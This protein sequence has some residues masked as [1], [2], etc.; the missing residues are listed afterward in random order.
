MERNTDTAI[1]KAQEEN[2]GSLW[3]GRGQNGAP[4]GI[5]IKSVWWEEYNLGMLQEG[6]LKWDTELHIFSTTK[7][8]LVHDFL[9][10]FRC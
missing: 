6:G 5:G 7:V 4:E 10:G 3:V 1:S 9:Q 8:D 2:V